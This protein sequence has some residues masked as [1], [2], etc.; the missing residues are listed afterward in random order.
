MSER[1]PKAKPSIGRRVLYALGIS[2]FLLVAFVLLYSMEFG[3]VE[4]YAEKAQFIVTPGESVQA[5]ADDLT[6]QGYVRGAWVF[7]LS[8]LR[9]TDG[10][11]IREGGYE[12]S[13]SMDALTIASALVEP[14]YY[15]WVK[16]PVGLRKEQIADLLT[17][18]LGWTKAEEIEFLTID[19]NTSPNYV[20]GV[21]F[22]DTYLIPTDQPPA[23]VAARLRARFQEAFAPYA[24]QAVK[25]NISW[26]TVVTIASLIQREAGSAAD[27]PLI[28]G[29]IQNR[30]HAGI[31]LAIDATL[32][33]MEGTSTTGW[34]PAPNAAGSY[35]DSPFNT[36]KRKGLPPHPIA[37]PG[38]AAIDAAL[39]PSDTSCLFYIH[40]QKGVMHC[41][42]T[43]KGQLANIQKYLK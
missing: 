3:P 24:D 40:D 39:N 36:Y 7:E 16:I 22:P 21:Y 10:R 6:K 37:N 14:P 17:H 4:Q 2:A 26:P 43:Y 31:P 27:M 42:P 41:S 20:E 1:P 9:E 38:L 33:Y 5:V 8:F 34:W 12:I 15:A 19:T 29:I 25:E 32:Q 30:L 11:G 18:A 13:K 35:P 23:Q 28:S